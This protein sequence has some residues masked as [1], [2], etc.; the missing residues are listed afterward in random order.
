[1]TMKKKKDTA[2]KKMFPLGAKMIWAATDEES[3]KL[4]A[5]LLKLRNDYRKAGG[6]FKKK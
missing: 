2:R 6:I 5:Q 4:F 3:K 1:M